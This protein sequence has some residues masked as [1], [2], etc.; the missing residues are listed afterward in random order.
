MNH[1]TITA[2]ELAREL[3]TAPNCMVIDVRTPAEFAEVHAAPARNLPLPD[4]STAALAAAGHTDRTAPVYL[5]CQTG[6]RA[7]AAAD[8]LAGE[9][10]AKPVVVTGGTEAWL[11]AGLPAVRSHNKAISLER[12]VRIAAGSFVLSGVILAQWVHPAFVWLAGFVGAGLVFAGITDF[13]GM[14]LLLARAPW[15]RARPAGT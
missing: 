7:L 4:V 3:S 11:A 9:G 5:L 15:N 2:A 10:F 1:A 8:R 12:Q 13:C 14:G 6:R